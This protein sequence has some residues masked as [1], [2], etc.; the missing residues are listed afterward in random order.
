MSWSGR[1]DCLNLAQSLD[2][3]RNGQCDSEHVVSIAA[4]DAIDL[5]ERALSEELDIAIAFEGLSRQLLNDGDQRFYCPGRF[6]AEQILLPYQLGLLDVAR[7]RHRVVL[8]CAGGREE[9]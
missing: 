8:G 9:T 1:V 3:G 5:V 4:L 7:E 2:L 6:D